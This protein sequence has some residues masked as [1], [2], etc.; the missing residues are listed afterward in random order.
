VR[1]S[2]RAI[3]PSMH[4]KLFEMFTVVNAW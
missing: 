4:Q 2:A 1:T 3:E